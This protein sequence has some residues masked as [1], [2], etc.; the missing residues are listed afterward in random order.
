[1]TEAPPPSIAR[2]L[3]KTVALVGLTA[4][5]MTSLRFSTTIAN[6][7]D[8]IA[9]TRLWSSL[10]SIAGASDATQRERLIVIGVAVACFLLALPIVQAGEWAVDRFRARR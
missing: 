6:G 9:G 5:L 1:M 8:H 10:Y 4:A 2:T 3:I 7:V